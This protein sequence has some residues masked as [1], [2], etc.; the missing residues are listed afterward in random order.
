MEFN[1]VILKQLQET[2][3]EIMDLIH[4]VCVENN[5][6]YSLA[7]GSSLGAFRHRGFIPWDDDID[8]MMLR[9]DYNRFIQVW[10][11]LSPQGYILQNFE[12]DITFDQNF[13]KI[14]KDHTCFLLKRE[15]CVSYHKGIFVDIV[16]RD[17]VAPKGVR[18]TIQ[19][20]ASAINLLYSRGFHD[21][22]TGIIG[23]LE[24]IFLMIP[25]KM[26]PVMRRMT[27][28]V[29]QHWNYRNDLPLYSPQTMERIRWHYPPRIF[30]EVELVEFE[31]RQ[32]YQICDVESALKVHYPEG[33]EQLPPPEKQIWK[34]RPVLIDFEKN[35]EEISHKGERCN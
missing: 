12:T 31:G 33:Y 5:I 32:Y 8:I 6:K 15:E 22:S 35:Y 26:Y 28:K 1:K 13:S 9:Q 27:S 24:H 14:R 34:H 11:E 16:P 20:C 2:E 4:R 10:S 23:L 29:I 25:K 21:G 3:L 30:D 17:R 7:D 18:R 19:Y